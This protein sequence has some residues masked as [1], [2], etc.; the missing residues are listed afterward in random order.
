[1]RPIIQPPE[2][3]GVNS[4]GERERERESIEVWNIK[5]KKRKEGNRRGEERRG[6]KG[7]GFKS[8]HVV[9][10]MLYLIISVN[11]AHTQRE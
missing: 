4:N 3:E 2:L 1:M 7:A 9:R 11:A 5:K 10:C 8:H 6:R